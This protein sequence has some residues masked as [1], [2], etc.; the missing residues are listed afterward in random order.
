MKN[1]IVKKKSKNESTKPVKRKFYLKRPTRL[2]LLLQ[3][4]FERN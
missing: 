3:T 2:Q 1:P 4:S